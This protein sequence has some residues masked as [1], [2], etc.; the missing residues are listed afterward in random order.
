MFFNSY[1]ASSFRKTVGNKEPIDFRPVSKK[2]FQLYFQVLN[3]FFSCSSIV[4]VYFPKAFPNG[5]FVNL[6]SSIT[7]L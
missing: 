2:F 6:A 4:F 3:L 7:P 5:E 1:V